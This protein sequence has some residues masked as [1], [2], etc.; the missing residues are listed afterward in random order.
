[1][2]SQYDFRI[3][4]SGQHERGAGL[5]PTGSVEAI[6]ARN[7]GFPRWLNRG[8]AENAASIAERGMDRVTPLSPVYYLTMGACESIPF[9]VEIL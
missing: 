5:E 8:E 6:S 4:Y 7:P 2:Q 1:M 3:L 9:L